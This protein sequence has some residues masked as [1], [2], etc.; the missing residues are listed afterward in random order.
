MKKLFTLMMAAFAA[1]ALVSCSDKIEEDGPSIV[2]T[3]YVG[4][5]TVEVAGVS[6]TEAAGVRTAVLEAMKDWDGYRFVFGE[7]WKVNTPKGESVYWITADQLALVHPG[8]DNI[9]V[10]TVDK[11]T[12]SELNLT[13]DALLQLA[14]EVVFPEAATGVDL[15]LFLKHK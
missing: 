8:Q 3:W 6:G 13:Y 11:L 15:H 4:S 9:S 7:D 10:F 2:G 12:P 1:F 14:D 5:M